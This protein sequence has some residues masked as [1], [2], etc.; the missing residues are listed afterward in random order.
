M[1]NKMEKMKVIIVDDDKLLGTTLTLGLEGLGMK[2]YYL[3]SLDGLMDKISEVHP[4]I[5]VL[6]VEIGSG[7]GIEELKELKLHAIHI[8]VIIMSSHIQM[9]YISEALA[10]GAFHFMKK[11]FEIEELGAYILRFAKIDEASAA[12]AIQIGSLTLNMASH[13]LCVQNNE[14][15]HLTKKQFEVLSVL[16]QNMGQTT[17]RQRLKQLLW[18]DGNYSEASLDNYISQ[19]RKILSIDET[20]RLETI[21]KLGFLLSVQ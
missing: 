1:V 14:Q 19:L 3:N 2:P 5:L 8:P 4:N 12:P 18:N 6:D 13:A 7:N 11:P 9:D 20:V 16:A 10:N 17:T 21:P 15:I